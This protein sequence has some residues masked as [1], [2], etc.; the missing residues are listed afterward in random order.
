MKLHEHERARSNLAGL[1]SP[2]QQA[3][4]KLLLAGRWPPLKPLPVFKYETH[5]YRA[6]IDF[7]KTRGEWVCRKTS[8]PSKKVQELR[9]GLTEIT[10]ALPY[11]QTEVFAEC[12]AAEQPEQESE[13]DATRR[14]QA[15]LD[16][17]GNYENG[18]LYS[19]LRD[20]LSKSQQGEI[21]ETIRLT[22][23]ARQLQCSPKNISYVF[24][25][26]LKAGGKLAT[27]I[28]IAQRNKTGQGA[29]VPAQAEGEATAPDAEHS[30]PVEA[31]PPTSD[32]RLHPR[33][34]PA[35]RAYVELDGTN[36]G[37]VLN[38]GE[39]G[40]AV[41][42]AG[43]LVVDDFHLPCIR[44]QLPSSG[45]SIEISGHIV[46][47]AES[48][49]SAGIRFVDLTAEARNQISNWIA[50]EKS[51]PTSEV[52]TSSTVESL[53]PATLESFA[54]EP[55][56]SVFPEQDQPSPLERIA[57]TASQ[58]SE[59]VTPEILDANLPLFVKDLQEKA[60]HPAPV[61]GL[62]SRVRRFKVE[63]SA[64]R[65][66]NS[67]LRKH[68]LEI[69]GLQVATIALVFFL[70]VIAL[71]VG[72]TVRRGPLGK[73]LWDTQKS[74]PT[75]DAMP[76]ALPNRPGETTSRTSAQPAVNA[77]L[78]SDNSSGANQ[79]ND[80]RRSEEKPRE[81]AR[82][83]ESFP[84][85]ASTD[86]NSSPTIEAKPSVNPE[87]LPARNG[88][89]GLIAENAPPHA[90][91]KPAH[92][93]KA[94]GSK[95]GALRNPAPRKLTPAMGA[96]PY[97]SPPSAILVAI[98]ARGGKPFRVT[99]P[100][101]PI[102][103]SSSIAMTSQLSVLVSPQPGLAAAHKPARLRAGEL[104]YFVWPRY[105]G[106]GDRYGSAE[107]IKVRTTIGQLGQV[108]NVKLVSGSISL[109][110]ATMSAIRQWRYKPTLLNKRPVQV[111][112][113]VTIEFRPP[114]YLSQVRTKH[115]SQK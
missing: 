72:V 39:T 66:E 52:L 27:L 64:D 60:H 14:L 15:M 43:P 7:D 3:E 100:E 68:V 74:M 78:D 22:L 35:S 26:L 89:P 32:R 109:L 2:V 70:A 13:K 65:K 29:G 81:S 88:S 24:D 25:A 75:V 4:M 82:N 23:T 99:F 62:G 54:E 5:E 101:K 51:A 90:N 108:L 93:P 105:S 55:I 71:T 92:S 110:P 20:F 61:H 16:W 30:S 67:P 19:G 97:V 36:G 40:M 8:L 91:P 50:S 57:H 31:F 59:I 79:L 95:S 46:W 86:A 73:R 115:P 45:P 69:S 83:S 102:A 85:V 37:T 111:Q 53:L 77:I 6:S 48:K 11:G 17:R 28:E 107:T 18:A 114:H 87:A 47:L 98:P 33:T 9:G 38:V 56:G 49:K 42:A 12:P 104:V 34:T 96:A 76:P 113:G 63:S 106:A 21:D 10:L 58:A 41:A 112:Q 94:V 80:A 1:V 44:L 84:K 103:A